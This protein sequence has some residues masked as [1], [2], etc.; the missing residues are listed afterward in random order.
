MHM[1][2][3]LMT[4]LTYIYRWELLRNW[5]KHLKDKEKYIPRFRDKQVVQAIRAE[6]AKEDLIKEIEKLIV[7]TSKLGIVENKDLG[8]LDLDSIE[9]QM[10]HS[11][12]IS[13]VMLPC[14]R[15]VNERWLR[16]FDSFPDSANTAI[17]EYFL[18]C[19]ESCKFGK[20]YN[21]KDVLIHTDEQRCFLILAGV[22]FDWCPQAY[23]HLR[24]LK[25]NA[26]N[27]DTVSFVRILLHSLKSTI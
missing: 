15:I 3:R 7:E 25:H 18:D 6:T 1:Y 27:L 9:M 23:F 20:L 17:E 16:L 4:L 8:C 19:F 26:A 10:R 12:I 2:K 24:K 13:G 14:Y 22:F 11:D 5:A 21:V